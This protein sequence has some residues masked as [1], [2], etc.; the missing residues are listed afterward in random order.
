MILYNGKVW[1]VEASQ[2][3]A[4]ALAVRGAKIIKVG[5]TSDV[6]ALQSATTELIDLQGKLVL[7]GFN[8]AHTHFENA[9]DWFFQVMV[10][11]VNEQEDLLRQLRAAAARVPR[12]MWI[13]GGDWGTFAWQAVQKKNLSG[14]QA[15]V[16]DLAA[17]DAVTPN[18]PVLL[19]RFDRRYFI[20]SA[21]MRLAAIV[22]PTGL[23]SSAAG[24]QVE[25]LLPPATRAQKLI[26]ARGVLRQLNAVGLTSIQDIAR[27][28]EISQRHT[29]PTFVE[30]SY[31]NVSIFR[32]L[33]E[34][35]E[36]SVRVHALTPLIT[37]AELADFGVRPGSG[38][39]WLNFGTLKDFVDGTLMFA[40]LAGNS[41]AFAFRFTGE[42]AIARN[43]IAA[44]RAGFDVGVHVLGDK[45]LH[46]LLNWYEAAV[47]ANGP[48]DRRFRMI[49]A[50]YAT[51]EDLAR[52][53]RLGLIADVTPHQLF[54]QEPET[55]ERALGPERAKT[56]F[57]WRTMIER[58]VRV[59]LVSDFPGLFNKTSIAPYDPLE[60]IYSAITRKDPARPDAAAWHPEQCLTIE[61][62]IRAYTVNPAY[63]S[64]E[65]DR[66]GTVA[67]GKLAD[68]VVLSRDILT[69]KPE[70]ILET[71]VAYT[72]L[73][74]KIVYKAP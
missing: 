47:A 59:S 6:L 39:E 19:R 22:E 12:G 74:G 60:N 55:L 31:S 9:V 21:G 68:L 7:P 35:G 29:F 28:D 67:E 42:E 30:R 44:D 8:D 41:G 4:Q 15:L 23:L 36:L 16:P 37:W 27:L 73:G 3:V 11:A 66:K 63:A 48:R 40:P 33:K 1:T 57:A 25:K 43:I 64:H 17:I 52:A 13:T 53:G 62:A 14:W 54:D 10:M 61:E 70:E 18:H 24:E 45:A 46:L 34:R 71:K 69:I 49:H 20:N 2:P 26:G 56:A 5:I 58:G 32:D 72:L 65:D 51:P 50:W 38:D